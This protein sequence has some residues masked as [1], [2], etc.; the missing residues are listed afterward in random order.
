MILINANS[1]FIFFS[2]DINF[3]NVFLSFIVENTFFEDN[4][5][6]CNKVV[7]GNLFFILSNF[8][9]KSL[10]FLSSLNNYLDFKMNK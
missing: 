5:I 7:I 1:V 10:S 6:D 2:F 4:P 3:N 9:Y 8:M